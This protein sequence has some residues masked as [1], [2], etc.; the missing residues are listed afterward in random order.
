MFGFIKFAQPDGAKVSLGKLLYA[1][2]RALSIAP[3]NT[4]LLY[5]VLFNA[6]MF[7]IAWAMWRKRWFVKV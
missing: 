5:A 2:I 3:V 6:F 7:A 1:P 4:S